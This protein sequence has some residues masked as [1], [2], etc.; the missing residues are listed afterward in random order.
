M[1]RSLSWRTPGEFQKMLERSSSH[2]DWLLTTARSHGASSKQAFSRS[3]CIRS[4]SICQFKFDRQ[5]RCSA[6]DQTKALQF[7][8]S[9]DYGL[10]R[11]AVYP[12]WPHVL[13]TKFVQPSQNGVIPTVKELSETFWHKIRAFTYDLKRLCLVRRWPCPPASQIT[14]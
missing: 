7:A 2:T 4:T 13:I 11:V 6:N 9:H 8:A 1:C 12:R 14:A 10:G 5:M 3:C